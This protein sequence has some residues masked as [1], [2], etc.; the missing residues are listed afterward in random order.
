MRAGLRSF[1]QGTVLCAGV[2]AVVL[3]LLP[4]ALNAEDKKLYRWV[5][6]VDQSIHYSQTP[7]AGV[8]Y[9][10]VEVKTAPSTGS[11]TQQRL[12]EMQKSVDEGIKSR[13]LSTEKQKQQAAE[14]AKRKSDCERMRDR[15]STLETRPG[16]ILYEDKS[17]QMTRMTEEKRQQN[18]AKFKKQIEELCSPKH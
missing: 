4:Q 13:E 2:S 7:P 8:T 3:C 18:I 9:E 16:K 15:L 1:L 10:N 5:D 12:Q 14:A 11:D 17:G 6:P